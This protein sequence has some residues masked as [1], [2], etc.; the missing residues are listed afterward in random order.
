M[1]TVTEADL[2]ALVD[3]RLDA[4]R[5]RE[6]ELHL[7]RCPRDAARVAA[8]VALLAGLRLLF[9]RPAVTPRRPKKASAPPP[10]RYTS[11]LA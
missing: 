9:G 2:L 4:P 3:G 6:V 10:R 5:R 7:T 1:N 8:D 11:F